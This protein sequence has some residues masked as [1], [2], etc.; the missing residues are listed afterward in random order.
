MKQKRIVIPLLSTLLVAPFVLNHDVAAEELASQAQAVTASLESTLPEERVS[1]E[2]QP[3]TT[4][5]EVQPMISES[6]SQD[7]S[8]RAAVAEKL[9][10][11]AVADKRML[12]SSAEDIKHLAQSLGMVS[13]TNPKWEEEVSAAEYG[14]MLEIAKKV[15]DATHAEKK[16]PLFLNG[17]AQPIFPYTSGA[18]TEGYSNEKSDII[19][20]TVYVETDY[21]TDGDGKRDLVK[22][23]VQVPRA[24][25]NGD[26]KASTIF[27]ARPYITG[28]TEMST[29][30]QLGLVEGAAYDMEKLKHQ[31]AKRIAAG[32]AR[33]KEA[34]VAAKSSDWYYYSPYEYAYAYEDL[35]WYD[36]FLVRGYAVVQS[37]GLG[38]YGSEG[39]NTT[40]SDLE[41]A[42]FKN[43]IEWLNGKRV[44][45]TDKTSNIQ[46]KADWANGKVGMTGLSWAGTST[47]GVAT[48]G[49]EGL[50]TIVPAAGI[51]SWYDY[52]NSQGTPY[53]LEPNS[54]L[55]WLSI[56][57]AGRILDQNDWATIKDKYAA[58]ISQLNKDQA[59]HGHD[60]SDLWK[61]RDYT[62]DAAK[63]KTPALIVHGLNDDNVKTKHFEL[64]LE[65]VE[66]A[67]QTAK[68][69]LHQ[70]NHVYPAKIARGYGIAANGESFYE[71]LNRWFSHYLYDVDNGIEKSPKVLAQNNDNP[72]KW[73][74]FD[75]WKSSKNLVLAAPKED[76][77]LT[78]TS[79]YYGSGIDWR[80][81]DA[82]VSRGSSKANLTYSM[83]VTED[84]IIKGHIPVTFKAALAKG[85]GK[86]LQINAMLV[87]VADEDFDVVSEKITYDANG[88]KSRE[89]PLN[90]VK[91]KG[92]WMG[93]NVENVDLK[94]YGTIK[95]NYKVIASGWVN[96]RNPESGWTS[97]SSSHSIE[98][99]IGQ[100]HDYT[101]YLQPTVYHVKKGHRLALVLTTYDTNSIYLSDLYDVTFQQDSIKAVIPIASQADFYQ[102]PV[103]E[104]SDIPV[105]QPE[106]EKNSGSNLSTG[107][108]VTSAISAAADELVNPLTSPASTPVQLPNTGE[109]ESYLSLAGLVLSISFG[110]TFLKKEKY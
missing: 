98:P 13:E 42:A 39:F 96:L 64:M 60:Y 77:K 89:L 11:E 76:K 47:F 79:D 18:V 35:T 104:T 72:D 94:N 100:F 99:Q 5:G 16:R 41:I 80:Y 74:A 34:A 45:Y 9:L 52:L 15:E 37:A 61:S 87:D 17:K 65:A 83:D 3:L 33:T 27:E 21:D 36:Y 43:I 54:N 20:Y 31:P 24:A 14:K 78:I 84:T 49:V 97:S 75:S 110:L 91:E 10:T 1:V 101:V 6:I 44:A 62:L 63:I 51:A 38:S 58:Y 71:L 59:A 4:E 93:S 22:A 56:Y 66:K 106:V 92:F 23:L 55:S 103:E 90:L 85:Q 107:E 95:T 28:T 68:L 86:N 88:Y 29:L 81:R 50:K 82:A 40:G 8:S 102:P 105:P 67:G 30:S 46:I 48:T 53:E 2:S 12:G 19:R 73:T 108:L 57:V 7:Q 69:Y 70:G 109:K 25:V 32:Q 26:F